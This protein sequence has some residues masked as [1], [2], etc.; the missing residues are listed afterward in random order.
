MCL[1]EKTQQ[2]VNSP[3]PFSRHRT[4]ALSQQSGKEAIYVFMNSAK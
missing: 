4:K 2:P 3:L 1:Q